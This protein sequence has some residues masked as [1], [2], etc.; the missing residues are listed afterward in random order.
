[1]A[2]S[3]STSAQNLSAYLVASQMKRKTP[4]SD[5][6]KII[7]DKPTDFTVQNN[8]KPVPPTGVHVSSCGKYGAIAYFTQKPAGVASLKQQG[9]IMAASLV[10][11][12]GNDAVGTKNANGI[13]LP[14]KGLTLGCTVGDDIQEGSP[15]FVTG[16]LAPDGLDGL[17]DPK[18]TTQPTFPCLALTE[19]TG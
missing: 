18:K 4:L 7:S 8:A 3:L 5:D 9:H 2:G 17:P 12:F 11:R 14:K 13:Q 1:M 10:S 19:Q 15:I 6:D 16:F